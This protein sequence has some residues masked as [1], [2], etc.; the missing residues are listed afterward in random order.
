MGSEAAV[1]RA[2]AATADLDRI[3]PTSLV[4]T[5]LLTSVLSQILRH[6]GEQH[7]AWQ[8]RLSLSSLALSFICSLSVY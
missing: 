5:S 1:A 4:L 3:V 8:T 2:T 7:H 6:Q